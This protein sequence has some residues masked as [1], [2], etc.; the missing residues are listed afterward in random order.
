MAKKLGLIII[1]GMGDTQPDFSGD[2]EK[3]LGQQLGS[4]IWRDMHLEPVYYQ[5]I[6]QNNQ[7]R[8][9]NDMQ[10]LPPN[11]LRWSQLR[12]FMLYGFA[13]AS[14]LEHNSTYDNSVYKKTQKIIVES[15]RRARQFLENKDSPLIVI[16][17]SLGGQIISNYIW[18]SQMAKGIWE[19]DNTDYINPSL[20][21]KDFIS[22]K[23]MRFL[24][25]TGCNIPLF[26]AGFD[27]IIPFDKSK[28]HPQFEWKNYYDR[29]DPLGWPLQPLSDE[30]N[31]L[32]K[33]IEIDSGNFLLNQTPFSH[34]EYWTDTDFCKPLINEIKKLLNS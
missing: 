7:R 2:L 5:S 23:T 31:Q 9:W 8:V 19:V 3:I 16:A 17:Q 11:K 30:Y 29:D 10:F 26:V 25:T 14:S 1:H 15:L 28:L 4:Q 21:E 22:L 24:F 12:K 6:L 13:D 18:D 27:K 32:V 20:E 34:N 33:D